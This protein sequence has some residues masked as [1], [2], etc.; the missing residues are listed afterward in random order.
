MIVDGGLA[1]HRGECRGQ[2]LPQPGSRAERKTGPEGVAGIHPT[3]VPRL[4]GAAISA[5]R[6]AQAP[7]HAN[8]RLE[9]ATG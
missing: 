3:Q 4:S 1:E 9:F 2:A 7:R 8:L 6:S 5:M